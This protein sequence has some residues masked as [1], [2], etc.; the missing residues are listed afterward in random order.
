ME[1]RVNGVLYVPIQEPSTEKTALTALNVIMPASDAGDNITVRDY[2][3]KLLD[4]LWEEGES[5]N[6]KRP[7]GNSGWEW[8]IINPLVRSGHIAGEIDEY[9]DVYC[10]DEEAANAFVFEIIRAAFYGAKTNEPN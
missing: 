1:V 6:G 2:L 10:E 3:F 5:F 7:F 4:T 9:D 8:D